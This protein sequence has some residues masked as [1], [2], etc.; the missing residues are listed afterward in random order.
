MIAYPVAQ[1]LRKWILLNSP[2]ISGEE[3]CKK[4]LSKE[5]FTTHY[6]ESYFI[7]QNFD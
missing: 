7:Y 6:F 5:N 3:S 1:A 2:N 4:Y